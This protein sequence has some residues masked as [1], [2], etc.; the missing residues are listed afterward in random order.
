MYV[1]H[2]A[3]ETMNGYS[4]WEYYS[5]D[6]YDDDPSLLK[7][8]PQ[9][10][11]PLQRGKAKK[12]NNGL[13]RGKKRKLA[14]TSDI[15]ELSLNGHSKP[16]LRS[17]GPWFKGTVWKTLS[18]EKGEKKLYQPG[19]GERVA[20]LDNWREV[21][22]ANQPLGNKRRKN[23]VCNQESSHKNIDTTIRSPSIERNLPR[24]IN[25]SESQEGP[26]A[27]EEDKEGS[28]R[29][30]LPR[31]SKA[32]SP[33]SPPKKKVVEV[34]VLRANG[35]PKMGQENRKQTKQ[36]PVTSRKRKAEAAGD[37]NENEE[38]PNPRAKRVASRKGVSK[39]KEEE[40]PPP[41]PP[42][43]VTRSRKK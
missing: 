16:E 41:L 22:K 9:E 39:T 37:E 6:Y 26:E 7:N 32:K 34:P 4:D 8:N 42:A 1:E 24:N 25:I 13:Q 18:P 10:G 17:M 29:R 20:L 35:V 5:D 30:K 23:N 19:M 43:R 12:P 36:N 40:K 3:D 21:F 2:P 27:L 33:R 14:A 31:T 28:K 15:P 11:S 38:E